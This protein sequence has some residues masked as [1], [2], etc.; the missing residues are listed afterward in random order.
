M[1]VEHRLVVAQGE[2]FGEGM[3]WEGGIGRYKLLYME[4]TDE[5]QGPTV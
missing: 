2:R 1:D 4:W 5:Q 3:D